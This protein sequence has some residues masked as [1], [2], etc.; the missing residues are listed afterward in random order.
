MSDNKRC[1]SETESIQLSN[2][3][4]YTLTGMLHKIY[5][6]FYVQKYKMTIFMMIN[7]R[8][9]AILIINKECLFWECGDVVAKYEYETESNY[10]DDSITY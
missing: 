8:I 10:R 7:K 9:R 1:D 3:R 5:I 6:R 4:V 2:Y